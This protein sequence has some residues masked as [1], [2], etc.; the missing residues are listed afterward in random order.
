MKYLYTTDKPI[1]AQ[2]V[3]MITHQ[4]V[5]GEFTAGEKLPSV[6]EMAEQAAVN[7]NTMQKALSELERN[8]LVFAQRTTGRFITE[9]TEMLSRVRQE[10][11]DKQAN[12]FLGNMWQLGYNKPQT[13]ELLQAIQEIK[14]TPDADPA[15]A[16]TIEPVA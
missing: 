14:I 10:L 7:P 12:T 5:S 6:R 16:I 8:G 1:Y 15:N 2:L 3:E 11:A 9:D 4:I 13:I